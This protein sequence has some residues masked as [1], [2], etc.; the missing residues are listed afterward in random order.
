MNAAAANSL[1]RRAA[2]LTALGEEGQV[3][4]FVFKTLLAFYLTGWLAMRL[5]LPQPTTAMMTCV[6]VANR[7]S[8]MVLAKSFYR[9]IGTLAGAA[10]A[11]LI[12]ALFPQQRVLLLGVLSLWI[13]LCA[14]G[15]TLHR[16][17]KSYAFVLA[18]Y[19]AAIVAIPVI[20][21]PPAVFD[22]AVARISEVLLAL[23]VSGIV[24]DVILPDRLRDLL[25]R[26]AR[27]QFAHLIDMVR[28]GTS[29]MGRD[30]LRAMHLRFVRDAVAFEDLRSSVIFEDPEARARSDHLRLFN[31][32]FM[33]AATTYLALQHL[34]Q[35]LQRRDSRFAYEALQRLY[36]Q[37]GEVLEGVQAASDAQPVLERWQQAASALPAAA[38]ELRRQLPEEAQRDFDSGVALLHRF[39][40]EMTAYLHTASA[41]QAP[42]LVG[43]ALEQ[44]HFERGNDYAGAALALLR[45]ALTLGSLA[46]FWIASAW[47]MG[48]S[49]MV[50]ATVFAGLLASSPT[51]MQSLRSTLIGY[52]AGMCVGYVCVFYVLTRMDGFALLA[53]GTVPFLLPGLVMMTWPSLTNVGIGYGMGFVYIAGLRNPMEFDPSRFLNDALSQMVGLSAVAVAFIVVPAVLGSAWLRRRQFEQLRRQV[54]LAAHAP[55]A[56][57]RHRFESVNH[58][59]FNQI[60][61]HTD[62]SSERLLSWAL[63]IG[64][65]GRVLIELRNEIGTRALDES[66]RG[67][68]EHAMD[69]VGQFYAAPEERG[70]LEAR[71]AVLEAMRQVEAMGDGTLMEQLHLLRLAL[72]DAHSPLGQYMPRPRAGTEVS[73]AA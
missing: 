11:L 43:P 72:L 7:Q 22:S 69:R 66:V 5:A 57:L 27:E 14:G 30:A 19:T 31:Q 18:G 58:D 4:A 32:R 56:G 37:L 2:V 21:N 73:N 55:L 28:R 36:R 70:Y 40:S 52:L 34:M 26:S 38:A 23:I 62:G 47:P 51:P 42:R 24:N 8:G 48:A 10:A 71:D 61:T 1:P 63:S 65:T 20:G 6:I 49:A 29:G 33:T 64:E 67:A 39:G 45:T 25:R 50:I 13:G 41:L 54:S 44:V 17:F 12:V 60:V 9:A 35:R 16:N 3:W 15:A 46:V 68:L 59:L 53:A